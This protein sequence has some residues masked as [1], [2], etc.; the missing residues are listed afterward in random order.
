[1]FVATLAINT[2]GHYPVSNKFIIELHMPG[3]RGNNRG[4]EAEKQVQEQISYDCRLDKI[5]A[6]RGYYMTD[7]FKAS[8]FSKEEVDAV[9]NE[10]T[11]SGK[12]FFA[13]H[14]MTPDGVLYSLNADAHYRTRPGHGLMNVL[15]C[16]LRKRIW[17]AQ[18]AT[19]IDVKLLMAAQRSIVPFV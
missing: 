9:A 11:V 17:G 7:S 5:Y 8:N 3:C 12:Y 13:A 6:D 10:T 15:T 1:M 4:D 18:Q 2:T 16:W 14:A 19:T